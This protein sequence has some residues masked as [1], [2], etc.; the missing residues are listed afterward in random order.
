M[1]FLAIWLLWF[2]IFR[3]IFRRRRNRQ[4]TLP[5]TTSY[6]AADGYTNTSYGNGN[7]YTAAS[8]YGNGS[9][10]EYYKNTNEMSEAYTTRPA[11]AYHPSGQE[12]A[13][14]AGAPPSGYGG[15]AGYAPPPGA[16]PK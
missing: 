8:S 3:A 9:A 12:Y 7:D 14:P 1:I 13:P 15:N 10:A 6:P 2:F 11:Q 16:P 5:T 4:Q